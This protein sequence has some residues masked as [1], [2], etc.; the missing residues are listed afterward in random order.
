[1]PRKSHL[2]PNR[3]GPSRRAF[4][5]S[6]LIILQL[7]CPDSKNRKRDGNFTT[8]T[9]QEEELPAR[10]RPPHSQGTGVFFTTAVLGGDTP[11]T[12]RER[13]SR[14]GARDSLSV[15]CSLL[16]GRPGTPRKP[17]VVETANNNCTGVFLQLSYVGASLCAEA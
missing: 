13:Q 3:S 11:K 8:H 12:G 17:D 2:L 10:I 1:M 4:V 7:L 5:P 9:Q 14:T 15:A 6:F 16:D